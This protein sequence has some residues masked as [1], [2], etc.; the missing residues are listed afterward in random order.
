MSK[1]IKIKYDDKLTFDNL[2][3]AH[4]RTSKNKNNKKCVMK[5]NIDLE[6][7]ILS[8]LNGLK[9]DTYRLGNYFVFKIYE[10]KERI[11][12]ALPYK[13]RI[14]QNW[15]IEEF[16]KPYIVPRFINDSYACIEGK[17]THKAVYKTQKY[18][19][20]MKRQDH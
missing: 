2:L 5:F 17:G 9:K 16:I 6:T 4:V 11:I 13:D 19:R 14:V 3:K 20:L 18:M 12:S 1:T 7:N 15:Y 8:I 10:P